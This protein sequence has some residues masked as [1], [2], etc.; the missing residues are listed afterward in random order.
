MKNLAK[1]IFYIPFYN[2]LIFFS[3]LTNGSVGWSIVLLTVLIRLILLPSSLKAAKSATKMQT[4]QPK[5]NEIKEKYK[6][7]Q[8][9]QNE[10]MMRLYKEEGASPFGA[11]LPLLIQ[12][13]ILLILYRVFT[14]GLDTSRYNLLYSFTPHP[15]T[16]QPIFLG[17]NLAKPDLWVLPILAGVMQ[18]ILSLMSMPKPVKNKDGKADPMQMMTRQMT[19]LFPIMTVFIGRSIPAA[20]TLYWVITT[21]FGIGQ[22]WYVN[23]N[24]KPKTS[25]LKTSEKES[26]DD[27]DQK[28]EPKQ[29]ESKEM[30]KEKPAK[31][32]MMTKIMKKR[33]DKQDRKKGVE[34]TIRSK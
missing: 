1:T 34:I 5:M 7:D 13:P 23:K 18:L 19:Y 29:I 28:E 31:S 20:L 9:K 27:K 2:L 22:Q 17:I 11:C 10:E 21:I 3:W 8:K 12:L 6:G 32:D 33:L 4:L 26:I 15:E 14:A 30:E 25:N 16:L 24:L